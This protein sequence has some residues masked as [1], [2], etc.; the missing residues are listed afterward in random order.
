ML[1]D[2]MIA[3]MCR[4]RSRCT[5]L[6]TIL[7]I[8]TISAALVVPS[9]VSSPRL[10]LAY[11]G[12]PLPYDNTVSV[13][14]SDAASNTSS[15]VVGNKVLRA[16]CNGSKYGSQLNVRSCLSALRQITGTETQLS[17]GV[18]HT[19]AGHASDIKLPYRWLSG[20]SLTLPTW[21]ELR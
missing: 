9:E 5:F 19:P 3:A 2:L 11:Q 1:W 14:L 7:H 4:S 20:E 17:F 15:T 13:N 6:A 8:S 21:S 12:Q 10:P 18:R 16:H